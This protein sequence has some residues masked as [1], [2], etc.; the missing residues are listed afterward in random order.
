MPWD[1]VF[2]II[3]AAVIGT[4][5]MGLVNVPYAQAPVWAKCIFTFTVCFALDLHG[6]KF[7]ALA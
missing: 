4:L 7:L 1:G 2:V 3:L 5:V 6:S